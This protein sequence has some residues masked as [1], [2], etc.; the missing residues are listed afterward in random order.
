M[1]DLKT[2][3]RKQVKAM[4]KEKKDSGK[5]AITDLVRRL[6]VVGDSVAG[7]TVSLKK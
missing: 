3:F 7:K 2:H 6:C 1:D 5:A 4:N